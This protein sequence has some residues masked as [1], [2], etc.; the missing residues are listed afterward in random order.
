M[1]LKLNKASFP[2]VTLIPEDGLMKKG[3]FLRI[4]LGTNLSMRLATALV[5]PKLCPGNAIY[6][7]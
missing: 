2:T 3:R 5:S 6:P 1:T 4:S 7:G